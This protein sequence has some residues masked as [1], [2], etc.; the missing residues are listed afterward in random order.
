MAVTALSSSRQENSL[1]LMDI[2]K[3]RFALTISVSA[4]TTTDITSLFSK[5]G[6]GKPKRTTFAFLRLNTDHTAMTF[7][8]GF[9]NWKA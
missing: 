7:D 8:Y 3:S 2:R 1:E 4:F 9:S 5:V 6:Q